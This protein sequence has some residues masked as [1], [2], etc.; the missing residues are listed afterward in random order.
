MKVLTSNTPRLIEKFY[1]TKIF[2]KELNENVYN[3]LE[4]IERKHNDLF[5]EER[6]KLSLNKSK[7][8][9]KKVL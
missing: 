3:F 7:K 6:R 9:L 5:N 1:E 8:Q 2:A 4:Y